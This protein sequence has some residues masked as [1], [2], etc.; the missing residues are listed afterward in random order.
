LGTLTG[1]AMLAWLVIA[2]PAVLL[3]TLILT[4]LLRRIPALAALETGSLT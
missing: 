4:V 1:H 3:M 2:V